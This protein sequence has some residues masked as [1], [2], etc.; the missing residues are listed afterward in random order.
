MIMDD[1]KRIQQTWDE[2][3][4]RVRPLK[5][6]VFVRT[7]P[8]FVRDES[9]LFLPPSRTNLYGDRMAH[10]VLV[11]A[12]VCAVGPVAR[13]HWKFEEGQRIVFK[14]LHFAW[15]R[16]MD[17]GT[18]FGYIDAAEILGEPT[19]LDPEVEEWLMGG[20]SVEEKVLAAE[21]CM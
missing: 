12:L 19:E 4:F 11:R 13:D 21:Y 6:K 9:G 2:L 14:R 10:Q 18:Y 7:E 15:L 17:D 16:K 8:L 20:L 5:F 1:S 3:G